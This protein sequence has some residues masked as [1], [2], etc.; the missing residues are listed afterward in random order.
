MGKQEGQKSNWLKNIPTDPLF[1]EKIFLLTPFSLDPLFVDGNIKV[2]VVE[3]K[4]GS[5]KLVF[6]APDDVEIFREELL[7]DSSPP[8]KT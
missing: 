1:V 2:T 8:E 3:T 4:N 7:D 6:D 5:V